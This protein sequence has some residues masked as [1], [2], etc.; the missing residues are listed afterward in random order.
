[1]KKY[2]VLIS[3]LIKIYLCS[4][5]IIVLSHHSFD[6]SKL[7]YKNGY[8][9]ATTD[10]V[11]R[12]EHNEGSLYTYVNG[13]YASENKEY[14]L[15]F[16][17]TTCGGPIGIPIGCDAPT[18]TYL[19]FYHQDKLLW[20]E[21]RLNSLNEVYFFEENGAIII[22]W[23]DAWADNYYLF[24]D[25]NGVIFDTIPI[26]DQIYDVTDNKKIIYH[27]EE[28]CDVIKCIDINNLMVWEKI[29]P[30]KNDKNRRL[31]VS[32][33]G[34]RFIIE[35]FDTIYSY[36]SLNNLVWK[37]Q[38]DNFDGQ[39]DISNSGKYFYKNILISK[40]KNNK[41]IKSYVAIFDNNTGDILYNIDTI[42]FNN[43]LSTYPYAHFVKN[44]DYLYFLN[45]DRINNSWDILITDIKGAEILSIS[46]QN[47]ST[48]HLVY[49]SGVFEIYENNKLIKTIKNKP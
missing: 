24:Y 47:T 19:E 39:S 12:S 20:S 14:Y 25:R 35:E 48:P 8:I 27:K 30:N 45:Y 33:N 43:I 9:H 2:Y 36:N 34:E 11:G 7:S 42:Y 49:L 41:A 38:N 23:T 46:V 28:E 32:E 16:F 18:N 15:I 1:M 44:S 40:D 26:S 37:I 13:I 17:D 29:L 22:K 3:V 31:H 21:Q 10:T 4:G 5:Q 6:L